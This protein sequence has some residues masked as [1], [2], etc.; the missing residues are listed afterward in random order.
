MGKM[1]EFYINIINS[2]LKDKEL[3]YRE[4]LEAAEYFEHEK[5]K[6]MEGITKD[7]VLLVAETLNFVPSNEE[8]EQV[9]ELLD[10]EASNDPT[11][12]WRC[13]IENLLYHLNVKRI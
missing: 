9:L 11:G 2:A 12:N 5:N 1:K 4:D 10:S 6:V 3:L 7:D 8:V 13:W